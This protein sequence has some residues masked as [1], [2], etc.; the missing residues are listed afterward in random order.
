MTCVTVPNLFLNRSRRSESARECGFDDLVTGD[1]RK[2]QNE[3]LYDL[4][5]TPDIIKV[6]K[7][8][9]IKW[10]GHVVRMGNTNN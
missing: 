3:E 10:A 6:I 9:R 1:W 2:L 7:S 8:G 4:F 5:C